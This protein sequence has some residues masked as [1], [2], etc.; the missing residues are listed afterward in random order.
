MRNY[1]HNFGAC[2]FFNITIYS[3]LWC[4]QL[5][6]LRMKVCLF[7]LPLRVI[8]A[9]PQSQIWESRY[10]FKDR[11]TGAW[12]KELIALL[13][14][15]MYQFSFHP[16][17]KENCPCFDFLLTFCPESHD[18]DCSIIW[19]DSSRASLWRLDI[20]EILPPFAAFGS[21]LNLLL[22]SLCLY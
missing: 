13:G 21:Y 19:V 22:F 3:S 8:I 2:C 9:E 6:D 20:V 18:A 15:T 10:A 16:I 17:L 14:L 12:I 11:F 4:L 5:S 7:C 1:Q